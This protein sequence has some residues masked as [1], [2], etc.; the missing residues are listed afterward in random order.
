MNFATLSDFGRAKIMTNAV[1]YRETKE[2]KCPKCKFG[3]LEVIR[4]KGIKKWAC[5]E[6]K[7]TEHVE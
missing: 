2:K 6:C 5:D 7:H 1:T 3:W 4:I